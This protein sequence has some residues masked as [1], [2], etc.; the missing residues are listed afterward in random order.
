MVHLFI[1]RPFNIIPHN[2]IQ[3]SNCLGAL[4]QTRMAYPHQTH[5]LSALLATVGKL[6]S[7]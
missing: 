6:Y 2:I 5:W 3:Y 7:G 1:A 4:S